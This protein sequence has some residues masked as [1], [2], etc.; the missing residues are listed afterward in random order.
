MT[1]MDEFGRPGESVP[2]VNPADLK[3]LW[4]DNHNLEAEH[5]TGAAAA[6]NVWKNLFSPNVDIVAVAYRCRVLSQL[7][8]F[9]VGGEPSKDVFEAA[10]R[11]SLIRPQVGVVRKGLPFDFEQLYVEVLKNKRGFAP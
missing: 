6:M 4:D 1:A 8:M 11:M 2:A 5:P 10:A 9:W 7:E 3:I